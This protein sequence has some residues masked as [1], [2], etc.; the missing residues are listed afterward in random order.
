MQLNQ[1]VAGATAHCTVLHSAQADLKAFR[2]VGTRD[3]ATQGSSGSLA[4]TANRRS[5]IV[6]REVSDISRGSVASTC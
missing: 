4:R 5:K 2:R 6:Y 1:D 3:Q